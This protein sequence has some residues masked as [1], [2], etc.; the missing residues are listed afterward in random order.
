MCVLVA[1]W[2]VLHGPAQEALM[3]SLP[4]MDGDPSGGCGSTNILLGPGSCHGS[5]WWVGGFFYFLFWWWRTGRDK[6][7]ASYR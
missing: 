1:A 3:R 2:P 5:G 6:K 7:T 4:R